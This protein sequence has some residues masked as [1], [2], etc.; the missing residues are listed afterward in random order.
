MTA[1][2]SM[3]S[4][5]NV[6]KRYG[7]RHA[8][9]DLS[10]EVE[11]GG[12]VGFLGP[13]GAGKTTTIRMITAYFMPSEGEIRVAGMDTAVDTLEVRRLI[14][15]LPEM[16][17]L[18]DD[19]RVS[20][21]LVY[22]ARLRGL[23][24]RMARARAEEVAELCSITDYY[25]TILG[26][27]SKGYRQRVGLA[28]AIVHDPKVL[29]LDEPTAGIDPVQVVQTRRLIRD[30]GAQRTVLLSTHILGEVTAICDRALILNNGRLV[31]QDS[32]ERL[33]HPASET[34]G[35][36]LEVTGGDPDAVGRTLGQIDSVATVD[37]R[38][39]YHFITYRPDRPPHAEI[40]KAV[41]AAGWTLSS[42][43]AIQPDLEDI[44]LRL[45]TTRRGEG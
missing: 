9:R 2:E 37:Y 44:F 14:G 6:S 43:E 45:T 3:I 20:D 24:R 40:G 16:A 1:A 18:Y 5:R 39:P 10:F 32:I 8:V 26:K 36:K 19:M 42:L 27:L 31:A 17:P 21:Y 34:S 30:L 7:E 29:I 33:T 38:P 41:V 23:S 28:Q 12:V 4:V 15:Y 25:H 22:T 11:T 13:N 35:L